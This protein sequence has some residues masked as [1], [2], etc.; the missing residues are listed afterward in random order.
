MKGSI[1]VARD[2]IPVR[3]AANQYYPYYPGGVLTEEDVRRILKT[4]MHRM[5]SPDSGRFR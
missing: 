2:T 5:K 4:V 3:P 1:L